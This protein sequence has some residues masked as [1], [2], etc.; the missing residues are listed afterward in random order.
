MGDLF[1][2]IG[3]LVR[4]DGVLIIACRECGRG[5]VKN[6]YEVRNLGIPDR[7]I[8]GLRFKCSGCGSR[9]TFSYAYLPATHTSLDKA[10]NGDLLFDE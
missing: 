1:R 8:D 2:T 9:K 7:Y 5:A 3:E 10:L 4:C 6:A